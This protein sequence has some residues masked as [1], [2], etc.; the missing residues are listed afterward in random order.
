MLYP[1]AIKKIISDGINT[2]LLETLCY[3]AYYA[4][5]IQ[6]HCSVGLTHSFAHQLSHY[7]VSHGIANA[8]FLKPVIDYKGLFDPILR[9]KL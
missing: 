9:L 2:D 3:S 7:G 6:N 5:I 4:G 8:M 1:K